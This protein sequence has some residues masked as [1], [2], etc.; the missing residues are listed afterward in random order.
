MCRHGFQ[1]PDADL[2]KEQF[3]CVRRSDNKNEFTR[4]G[5]GDGLLMIN[6]GAKNNNFKIQALQGKLFIRNG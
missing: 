4:T 6:T 3:R 5:G 1:V 2:E